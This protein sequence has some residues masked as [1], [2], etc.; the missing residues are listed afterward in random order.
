V[1]RKPFDSDAQPGRI[2]RLQIW[3]KKRGLPYFHFCGWDRE[4]QSCYA[5]PRFTFF[6]AHHAFMFDPPAY[7]RDIDWEATHERDSNLAVVRRYWHRPGFI[8]IPPREMS[9]EEK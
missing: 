9:K 2:L 3:L 5:G 8:H 1:R 4:C 7:R 6:V